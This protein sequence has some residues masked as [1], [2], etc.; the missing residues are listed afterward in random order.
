MV[1]ERPYGEIIVR[2][3]CRRGVPPRNGH[4]GWAHCGRASPLGPLVPSSSASSAAWGIITSAGISSDVWPPWNRCVQPSL[5]QTR[6]RQGHRG[7]GHRQQGI[8]PVDPYAH[9]NPTS[10]MESDPGGQAE[11]AVPAGHLPGTGYIP[12]Y[13]AQIL[14]R[15]QKDK[16]SCDHYAT[17]Q[18]SQANPLDKFPF[19]LM[20]HSRW[21]TT[22]FRDFLA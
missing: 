2:Y 4:P 9:A 16:T 10:P 17:P 21:T 6:G 18:P 11:R 20:G 13:R 5:P 8:Q 22:L 14:L 3:E 15:R 19:H 12:R 7:E 1:L